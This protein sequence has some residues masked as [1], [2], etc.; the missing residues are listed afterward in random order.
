MINITNPSP[1]NSL[2]DILE[3]LIAQARIYERILPA[4]NTPARSVVAV[5]GDLARKAKNEAE[6]L[7]DLLAPPMPAEHPF[8]AR[9]C[10]VLILAARGLTNKEIA[11]RL[12]ISE[13]TVQFHL[14]SIFNKTSTSSRT[15]A[16]ALAIRM[17]WLLPDQE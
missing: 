9:E 14:A 15:E 4:D 8:S 1:L 13:R 2:L 3:L 12:G 17:H 5:L 10:Q 7:A 6:T 16:A 11:Y